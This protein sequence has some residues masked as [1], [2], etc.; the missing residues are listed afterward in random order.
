MSDDKIFSLLDA[1]DIKE[2]RNHGK[3]MT[4]TT[5]S[6]EATIVSFPG[7]RP[8]PA[9]GES[10]TI[11]PDEKILRQEVGRHI[12]D[13]V[14]PGE[15]IGL[16][17]RIHLVPFADIKLD[18]ERSDLVKGLIPRVGL[19]VL[20]GAPKCGKTFWIFDCMMHV[21]LGW[22][23]RGK[24]VHQGVVVYCAFEGQQGIKKRKEAFVQQ[25][26]ENYGETVPFF[27]MPVTMDLVKDGPALIAAIEKTLGDL[28]PVAVVLDTLN[29]SLRGSESSDEDMSAYVAAS[30]RIRETFSCAIVVVHHCGLDATRPRG[31]TA[32]AGALDSQLACKRDGSDN[33]V[34]KV[35][36]MKD[37]EEGEV[38]ASKLETVI[39]GKNQ[40]GDDI[41]SC[42]I[43]PIDDF[44]EPTDAKKPRKLSDR[45]SLSLAALDE[46]TLAE[47]K[48]AP[49]SMQL[50][51]AVRVVPV[52]AWRAE[53]LVRGII[54]RESKNPRVDFNRIKTKL[55][56]RGLIG[57]RD[58]LVW[59]VSQP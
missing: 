51:T 24:R 17:S 4:K 9:G 8:L 35:E 49:P 29:R 20:W 36:L 1:D 15:R 16:A 34:V 21:A 19:T 22:K 27:L 14:L 23:Y 46:V 32:L 47:G 53:V 10:I 7:D 28:A 59:K 52:E 45:D 11:T 43:V 3:K 37:G 57:E 50:P 56:G 18:T 5:T 39:V 13:S 2:L 33:V 55:T 6:S 38:I 26:L 42:V 40:D 30:D 58:G 12:M 31:H 54:D 44:D 25:H 48:H 41:T